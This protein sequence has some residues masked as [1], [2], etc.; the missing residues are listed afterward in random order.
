MERR[1]KSADHTRQVISKTSAN[2]RLA[3][4]NTSTTSIDHKHSIVIGLTKVRRDGSIQKYDS[5]NRK[6][7]FTHP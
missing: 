7:K 6:R 5:T 1:N 4:Q 3:E 2:D